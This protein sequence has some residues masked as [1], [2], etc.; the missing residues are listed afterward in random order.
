MAKSV[1]KNKRL[2]R[3][4][5]ILAVLVIVGFFV[6]RAFFSKTRFL[7]GAATQPLEC[8]PGTS[9]ITQTYPDE[10]VTDQ[11]SGACPP[12][13]DS[14]YGNCWWP[15]WMKTRA[16]CKQH[17]ETWNKCGNGQELYNACINA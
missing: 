6:W 3:N 12:G 5:F 9:N 14:E 17:I 8:K 4:L 1:F 2:V 15:D 7:E 16:D 10:K 13:Y 11:V